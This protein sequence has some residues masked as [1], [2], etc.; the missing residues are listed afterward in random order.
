MNLLY[1]TGSC[2]CRH[3][4]EG[5][6]CTYPSPGRFY[7]AL[8]YLLF[9]AE[10]A[11]GTFISNTPTSAMGSAFTG[12]GYAELP[13]DKM[14]HFSNI[15]VK[16]TNK[17]TVI[18]RYS[19]SGQCTYGNTTFNIT[20]PNVNEVEVISASDIIL[21]NG[22]AGQ[23]PELVTLV[24]GED[25]NVTVSFN[26]SSD[27]KVLI[28]SLVVIPYVNASRVFTMSAQ[29]HQNTL[30][31]CVTKR[32]SL[33]SIPTEP[34]NCSKLVFSASTQIYNGTLGK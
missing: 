24:S 16:V 31:Q 17:Y 29:H 32:A 23:L 26:G 11:T 9:E 19:A 1:T 13:P 14:V 15:K 4:V 22:R 8:D 2:H 10:S 18:V 7:P 33:S 21:G 28:D 34:A 3:G 30:M 5:N 20:G 12:R 25:Y 27:C 6:Q